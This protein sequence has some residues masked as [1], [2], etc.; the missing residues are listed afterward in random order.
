MAERLCDRQETAVRIRHWEQRRCE[1]HGY[2]WKARLPVGEG[3]EFEP[4]WTTVHGVT[5]TPRPTEFSASQGI[6]T[7]PAMYRVLTPGN[8]VRLLVIPRPRSCSGVVRKRVRT[9]GLQPVRC[10]CTDRCDRTGSFAFS[11][12]RRPVR[13][14]SRSPSLASSMAEHLCHRQGEVV[15]LHRWARNADATRWVTSTS[16]RMTRV[17]I[18]PPAPMPV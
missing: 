18:P 17:R 5:H 10:V 14:G 8:E 9:S 2:F 6:K 3:A 4:S 1:G 12:V 13:T 15:R 7:L 11:A 16:N